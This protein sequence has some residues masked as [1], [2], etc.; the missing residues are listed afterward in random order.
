M[1]H[2]LTA[3]RDLLLDFEFLDFP[4]HER[5]RPTARTRR[6]RSP[7]VAAISAGF[8]CEPLSGDFDDSG[9]VRLRGRAD[10]H[11][12]ERHDRDNGHLPE[13][14]HAVVAVEQARCPSRDEKRGVNSTAPAMRV[15]RAVN[16]YDF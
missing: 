10:V 15:T 2:G 8:E 14:R 3:S 13:R 1:V 6:T 4:G 5:H 7:T 12:D 9:F 16:D 11:N